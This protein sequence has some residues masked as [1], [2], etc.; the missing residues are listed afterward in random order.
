[1]NLYADLILEH[2]RHPQNYG[3]LNDA[4]LEAYVVNPLCGDEIRL[5]LKLKRSTV[6]SEQSTVIE[7]VAFIGNGCAISQAAAS[8]ITEEIKGGKLTDLTKLTE[9]KIISFLGI[10]PGPARIKCA[11]L[12]LKALKRALQSEIV[13]N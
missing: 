11:T 3:R 9:E 6:N 1:M 5:Q 13:A 4:D 2:W 12:A 8:I 7:R 10:R